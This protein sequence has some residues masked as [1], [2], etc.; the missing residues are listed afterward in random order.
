MASLDDAYRRVE[1]SK[2]RLSDF[3]V[4]I[5]EFRELQHDVVVPQLNRRNPRDV[6]YEFPN[7]IK[8]FELD[9]SEIVQPL[10]TA[11]NYL[12]SSLVILNSK[13]INESL[14]FP[15]CETP[16]DFARQIPSLLKGVKGKQVTVIEKLQPYNGNTWIRKI[17]ELTDTD[18]HRDPIFMRTSGQTMYRIPFHVFNRQT[19]SGVVNDPMHVEYN[20]TLPIKFRDESPVIETLELLQLK[21]ADVL[22]AFQSFF[23]D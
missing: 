6:S 5:E 22:D 14:Q 7:P 15:I 11:L 1:R 17:R 8:S 13:P 18:K 3:K 16:K 2:E 10:R 23:E 20:L 12:V 9:V 4:R 19:P 21:V